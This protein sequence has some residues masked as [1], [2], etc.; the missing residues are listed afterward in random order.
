MGKE[1]ASSRKP[2]AFLPAST[3]L[4]SSQTGIKRRQ[5][6]IQL[7]QRSRKQRRVAPS[8][9]RRILVLYRKVSD[10]R[11]FARHF[12]EN[13][14][15][16]IATLLRNLY[17]LVLKK[18]EFVQ[19]SAVEWSIQHEPFCLY[20]ACAPRSWKPFPIRL[21]SQKRYSSRGSLT[22]VPSNVS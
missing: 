13:F 2:P 6:C 19:F 16:I 11:H 17:L 20:N 8:F 21:Y 18:A 1:R 7:Y 10:T 4:F 9:V 12:G 22:Q 3:L 5:S 14:A 15:R